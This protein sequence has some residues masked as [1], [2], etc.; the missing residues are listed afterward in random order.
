MNIA[1][2]G[3]M[4]GIA[5]S[6]SLAGGTAGKYWMDHEYVPI[7]SLEK[8]FNERDIRDIKRM[9]RKLEYLKQHNKITPQEQ[10]ELQGL[11]QE[12]DDLQ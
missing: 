3:V 8:A 5:M 2:I 11:Y 4:L 6:V 9:I 1:D 10:W 12:L 7:G